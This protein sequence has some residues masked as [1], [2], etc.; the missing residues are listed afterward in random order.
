M[1]AIPEP[2]ATQGTGPQRTG[3]F[4]LPNEVPPLLVLVQLFRI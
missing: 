4:D 2:A 3:V 1:A